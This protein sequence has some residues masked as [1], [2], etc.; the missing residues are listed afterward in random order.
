MSKYPPPPHPH[1]PIQI[2]L[3]MVDVALPAFA[4]TIT[5]VICD[6]T[7]A[8]SAGLLDFQRVY[9]DKSVAAVTPLKTLS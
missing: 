2:N 7:G 8:A 3:L 1:P 9:S 6:Q 5:H 4:T